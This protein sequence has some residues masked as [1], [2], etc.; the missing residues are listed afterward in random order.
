MLVLIRLSAIR[1]P[2]LSTSEA[3]AWQFTVGTSEDGA[4]YYNSEQTQAINSTLTLLPQ[5]LSV[6]CKADSLHSFHCPSH[7]QKMHSGL[8]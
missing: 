8:R 7:L 5:D 1:F 2:V 3:W 4:V 6:K